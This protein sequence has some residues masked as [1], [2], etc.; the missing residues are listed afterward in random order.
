[1]APP[2]GR[3]GADG[4]E[5][6]QGL[7]EA[8]TSRV[9]SLQPRRRGGRF[10]LVVDGHEADG[11]GGAVEPLRAG[12]LDR[13]GR[14]GL[15]GPSSAADGRM[16]CTPAP[17]GRDGGHDDVAASARCAPTGTRPT[18]AGSAS[19]RPSP[20]SRR[21]ARRRSTRATCRRPSSS[22]TARRPCSGRSRSAGSTVQFVWIQ[23]RVKRCVTRSASVARRGRPGRAQVA[24]R[25][26]VRA[27]DRGAGDR[28]RAAR[29]LRQPQRARRRATTRGAA[30]LRRGHRDGRRRRGRAGRTRR[31]RGRRCS[32]RPPAGRRTAA[33][34]RGR[35]TGRP[36]G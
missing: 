10:L 21:A 33:R 17:A 23:S 4:Q 18:R 13:R 12:D 1:M 28:A 15:A 16:T 2:P 5:S 31:A 19:S 22:G 36:A 25:P 6:A 29:R 8:S 20:A 9:G 24:E 3:R 14:A 27:A 35:R 30:D 32:R 7:R 34:G 11:Q 26:G